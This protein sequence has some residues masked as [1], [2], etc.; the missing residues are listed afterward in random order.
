MTLYTLDKYNKNFEFENTPRVWNS[1]KITTKKTVPWQLL[2]PRSMQEVCTMPKIK[3]N[4]RKIRQRL[5][6]GGYQRFY[7]T[8][9][10]KAAGVEPFSNP[11]VTKVVL[12]SLCAVNACSIDGTLG[13]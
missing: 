9:A 3:T 10:R 12:T 2:T 7:E 5:D 4:E 13:T 6:S 1:Q 8:R 11:K